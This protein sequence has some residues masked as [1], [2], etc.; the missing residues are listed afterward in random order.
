VPI[1]M[2]AV[3]VERPLGSGAEE[4]IVM[5]FLK[6][7]GAQMR[8]V[9]AAYGKTKIL[10]LG[11]GAVGI[12]ADVVSW[13][14]A[15]ALGHIYIPQSSIMEKFHSLLDIA[16][17][18]ALE[19]DGYNTLVLAGR[20]NHFAT[21]P[22]I[23][24]AGLFDVDVLSCLAG[25]YSEKG[26]P[27][28]GGSG[29]DGVDIFIIKDAAKVVLGGGRRALDIPDFP[30]AF[31]EEVFVD[32]AQSLDADVRNLGKSLGKAIAAASDTNDSHVDAVIGTD[33]A[34]SGDGNGSRGTT[35]CQGASGENPCRR[36][37][38][39]IKELT[40]RKWFAFGSHLFFSVTYY[41]ITK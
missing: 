39:A 30:D 26:V 2:E 1:V 7:I 32:I 23:M 16:V 21:L 19:A 27:M 12:S 15:Q 22:D 37:G 5:N 36:L 25:P 3:A 28:V 18:A 11:D 41:V 38:T 40:T 9:A 29:G 14:V 35:G 6:I 17:G 20:F 4:K 13:L 10:A 8:H 24:G 34:T 33:D 31:G